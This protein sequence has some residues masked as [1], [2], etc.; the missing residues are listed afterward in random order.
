MYPFHH[1]VQKCPDFN[2]REPAGDRVVIC[3]MRNPGNMVG[4]QQRAVSCW[5]ALKQCGPTDLGLDLDHHVD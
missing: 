4:H 5:W 2:Y 1:E 3:D